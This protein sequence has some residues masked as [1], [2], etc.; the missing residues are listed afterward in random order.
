[1]LNMEVTDNYDW[2]SYCNGNPE[3]MQR[4]FKRHKE[5]MYTYAVYLTGDPVESEDAIQE[6]FVRLMRQ[7]TGTSQIAS[8][9]NWLFVTLRN[10]LLNRLKQNKIRCRIIENLPRNSISQISLETKVFIE[11]VIERLEPDERDLILLREMQQIPLHRLAEMDQCSE[12]T[13]RVRLYR[14]RKKMQEIA[15]E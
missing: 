8:V 14:I 6:T 3:G 5:A 13:I 12:G 1:M 10:F 9:E 11:R 7:K 2:E 15:K 4:I